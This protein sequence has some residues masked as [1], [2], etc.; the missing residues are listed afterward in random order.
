MGG[1]EREEDQ[2]GPGALWALGPKNGRELKEACACL[3]SMKP[4]VGSLLLRREGPGAA[5][6]H[7]L[8]LLSPG[9][10]PMAPPSMRPPTSFAQLASLQLQPA[11]HG[12][13]PQPARQALVITDSAPAR[14]RTPHCLRI[15]AQERA[16]MEADARGGPREEV[17][18]MGPEGLG[19]SFWSGWKTHDRKGRD[20]EWTLG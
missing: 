6:S 2:P 16:A 19:S 9:W 7:L 3:A 12:T 10:W 17:S 18:V 20:S 4:L 8:H 11:S 15:L 5:G 14:A 1:A 13:G